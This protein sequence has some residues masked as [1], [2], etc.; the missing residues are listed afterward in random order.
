MT[1]ST[2][3]VFVDGDKAFDM[4]ADFAQASSNLRI[5]GD[6]TPFQVADASHRTGKAAQL[7]LEWANNQGWSLPTGE[8][9]VE[10]SMTKDDATEWV[11]DQDESGDVDEDDLRAAY[12]AL[13][14]S[15]PDEDMTTP[16]MWSHC[17]NATANCGTRPN[18]PFTDLG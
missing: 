4:T 11:Y 8:I 14:E 5:D 17:C 9:D 7:L 3:T 6:S 16:D 1:T 2:Y 12:V 13:Y 18:S 10:P 15:I